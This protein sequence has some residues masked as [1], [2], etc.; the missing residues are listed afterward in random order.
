V[1]HSVLENDVRHKFFHVSNGSVSFGSDCQAALYYTF[2][3][4][5]TTTSTKNSFDLTMATRK[6]LDRLPISFSHHHVPAHQDISPD[7]IHI[8]GRANDNC[9]TDA[10]AFWKKEKEEAA[11]TLVTS[12]DLCDEPYKV[13]NFHRMLKETCTTS[14]MTRKQQRHGM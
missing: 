13:K 8:W 12:T 3:Q 4:H 7:E 6:V 5:K 2:D 1:G 9:D 10:N 11:G 14:S